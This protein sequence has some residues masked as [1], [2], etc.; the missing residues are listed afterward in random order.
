MRNHHG[1]Q[2][3]FVALAIESHAYKP[4]CC[5]KGA[6]PVACLGK[7]GDSAVHIVEV[8]QGHCCRLG[9]LPHA[10]QARHHLLCHLVRLALIPPEPPCSMT[11]KQSE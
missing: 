3:G 4:V 1:S 10:G 6:A 11:H 7:Q 8:L 5:V 2:V 9:W